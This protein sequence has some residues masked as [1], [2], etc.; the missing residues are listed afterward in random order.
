MTAPLPPPR[1]DDTARADTTSADATPSGPPSADAPA[2]GAPAPPRPAARRASHLVGGLILL[3]AGVLWLLDVTDVVDLRWRAILP[4]GLV[5]VGLAVLVLSLWD[6]AGELIAVG[7]V[8][9]VLVV[10]SALLPDQLSARVG[11]Q[12]QRP[13][14]AADLRDQYSHGI[15]QLTIDLRDL[16]VSDLPAD[17]TVAASI[18]V[19][20]LQVRVPT[21]NLTVVVVGSVGVGE[22]SAFGRTSSGF[23][24]DLD[25]SSPADGPVLRLELSAGIGRIEVTREVTR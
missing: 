25:E 23:A 17:T 5:V 20:E 7:V 21:D 18:G 19:G 11:E 6:R 24:V 9:T 1:P 12:S 14:A 2:P 22:V 4:A 8:L 16:A 13:V 10:A 15:G 3:T